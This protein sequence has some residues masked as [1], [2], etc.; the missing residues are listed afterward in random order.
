[1]PAAA[2]TIAAQNR[3]RL[4]LYGRPGI[5]TSFLRRRRTRARA[6]RYPPF[7]DHGFTEVDPA[8][9]SHPAVRSSFRT[10]TSSGGIIYTSDSDGALVPVQPPLGRPWRGPSSLAPDT[11]LVRICSSRRRATVGPSYGRLRDLGLFHVAQITLSD[12]HVGSMTRDLWRVGPWSGKQP[13]IERAS[14]ADLAFLA[15][16]AGKLPQQFAAILRFEPSGDFSLARLRQVI[17]ER[18]LAMP[19]LRQR[20]VRAPVGCGHPVWVDDHD[21]HIDQ[22]VRA[23]SCRPPGNERALFDTALSVIM[24]PLPKKAP[25]WSV[26]LI[27]GL[28]D[29]RAAVVVVLH[30]VLADGLGGL[31]VLA[32]LVDPGL[33]AAG[34]PFPRPRPALPVLAR[35][36]LLTRLRGIRHPA[37]SWRSLRQAMF[38]GGGFRPDPA[39]PCSLVQPTSSR[40]RMAAIRLER[41]PLAAAAHRKGATAN[42]AVLVAVGAALHEILPRRGES[43]DPI[44]ITVPVS[45]RGSR[46]G[47]AMGNLVS[48][49]LVEVPTSGAVRER[50]AQVEAAVR[51]HKAAATG[52]PP[53]AIMGGLFRVVARLGGYRYYMNHQRRF[54]TLVT[55]VRGPAEPLTL[56]GHPVS[57]AIPVAIGERGNITVSFEALSYAGM[58]TITVIVDPEHGPDLDDLIRRL[59]HELDSIIASP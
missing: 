3:R 35:D 16:E 5:R 14:S 55:H 24:E 12:R 58:L 56:D 57:E 30:H 42:D 34:V 23:V 41:A 50:L 49:M 44:A 20:L 36:A 59:Q 8:R 27:T 31:N 15:M 48:P 26:V 46:P 39:V 7:P 9:A 13:V 21:F 18:I 19:R 17:S 22:H 6:P 51:A 52:P 37:G 54:H 29:G 45:G 28:P 53:I 47:S 38:A 11:I 33:K 1:M 43:V 40:L 2:A 10:S 25:L 4:S 32:A